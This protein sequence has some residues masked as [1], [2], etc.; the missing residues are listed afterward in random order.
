M[1]KIQEEF[2]NLFSEYK[3]LNIAIY[4]T[5]NNAQLIL[6]NVSGY[7]FT[8]LVSKD[9]IG[10][11]VCGKKVV[12]LEDAVHTSQM[13]IIAAVPASTAIIYE[14][15]RET[16]PKDYPIFDMRGN[17]MSGA[18]QYRENPY[19]E[20][21]AEQLKKL[22]EQK[23]VISFDI[24][25]TLI[26]RTV[27]EPTDVFRMV[28]ERLHLEGMGISF[29]KWRIAA[30]KKCNAEA[31]APTFVQIYEAM[32]MEYSLD[33]VA[34]ARAM[35][36]EW[37]T[38]LEVIRPRK[39][40]KELLEWTISIGKKVYLTSDM[41]F[42]KSD[43]QKLLAKAEIYV[44]VPILISSEYGKSKAEGSLYK[45][46]LEKAQST[47]LLHIGDNYENDIQMAKRHGIDTFYV[48][49]GYEMLAE[50]SCGFLI[51]RINSFDDRRVLG[52]AIAKICNNPFVLHETKGKF[53]IDN[54]CKLAWCIVP[55]TLL[56]MSEIVRN[57]NKYDVILFAARDGFFLNRLYGDI[58]KKSTKELA[59]GEYF[60]VS[61]SAVSSAS[62]FSAE[63]INVLSNFVREDSNLNLKNF[64]YTQFHIEVADEYDMSM[65]EAYKNLGKEGIYDFLRLYED[66]IIEKSERC[67]DNYWKYIRRVGVDKAE[68]IAVV[69]IVTQGT[70]IYGLSNML[71]KEIDL[72][73]LGTTGIP[74]KYVR[75]IKRVSSVYG[76]VYEKIGEVVYS[77]SDF[78]ELHLF[79]EMLYGSTEGQLFEFSDMGN[80]VMVQ[81]TEYNAELMHGTQNEMMTII[82][83]FGIDYYKMEIS[84]EFALAFLSI[85]YHKYSDKSK[86]IVAQFAFQDPY[87]GNMQKC[88]LMEFLS[89]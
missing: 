30:E 78:A 14:R 44:D 3:K 25:D 66:T 29:Y 71:D 13:L 38:E 84:K 54:Y 64:M 15:I 53:C 70:L 51:D 77:F 86:E 10:N 37:E 6:N 26:T 56:F 23:D 31:V 27:L 79:L 36:L 89:N 87:D 61:R 52:T 75:D 4:G 8:N 67:R 43:I 83:E 41:Y 60:Y 80:P 73:A 47:K 40:M 85:L 55:I 11:I 2:D 59:K 21:N 42:S 5:G 45:I 16:V 65:A 81:G 1:S 35:E 76:N 9:N 62:V 49:R 68:K 57:A 32:K 33:A 18:E 50:S 74:N 88:N 12:N 58:R 7:Q 46:L 72:L 69:D 24:F 82:N 39:A 22:I 48:K 63:D 19:W 28:E 34:V 17:R 20:S